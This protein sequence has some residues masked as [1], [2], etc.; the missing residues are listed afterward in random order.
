MHRRTTE[1]AMPRTAPSPR[2][3]PRRRSRRAAAPFGAALCAFTTLT[4]LGTATLPAAANAPVA[5]VRTASASTQ[6]STQSPAASPVVTRDDH[7]RSEALRAALVGLPDDEATAAVV[8]AGGRD[9]RFEGSAGVRDIRSG[10]A[11]LADGRIRAGSVT[12]VVNASVVL[13]LAAENRLSLDST[14]QELLPGLLTDDFIQPVTVRNLLNHTSGIQAGA[15][16][17]G[18]WEEQYA[19]RFDRLPVAEVVRTAVAKGPA[20]APGEQQ[21]YLNINYTL[22]ALIVEKV[23]GHPFEAE[24]TRRVLRPLGMRASYFPGDEVGIRG[25]HNRGYQ[26]VDG[27]RVDVTRWR[28]TDRWAAGDL[29]SSPAD[30]ER[31]LVGV[32]TGKAVPRSQLEEMFTV[33]DIDG[34]T[35]SAGLERFDLGDGKVVWGKSG[36]RPGYNAGIAATR[37]LSRTVVYGVTGTTAKESG[38]PVAARFGIPAFG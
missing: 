21:Q 28:M 26:L 14:V 19:H 5:T 1:T 31:L 4:L 29:V 20:F 11:A 36:A 15:G 25:A 7:P 24:A 37:N 6:T 32:F 18:P 33:P 13:Q 8:L 34:A 30:L 17:N 16:L 38:G 27:V 23:T 3:S 12:K 35:M 22:L 9:G 2:T 10:R